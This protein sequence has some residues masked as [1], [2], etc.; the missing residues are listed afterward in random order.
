M[1]LDFWG[2]A[3]LYMYFSADQPAADNKRQ[4]FPANIF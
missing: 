3:M 4:A 2:G 1:N